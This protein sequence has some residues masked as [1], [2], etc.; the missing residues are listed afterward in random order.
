MFRLNVGRAE[1]LVVGEGCRPAELPVVRTLGSDPARLGRSSESS[2]IHGRFLEH[3]N[4][5]SIGPVS[6]FVGRCGPICEGPHRAFIEAVAVVTRDSGGVL[7]R[8]AVESGRDTRQVPLAST[9]GA[10]ARR[11][12]GTGCGSV[13]DSPDSGA[14]QWLSL[15]DRRR[16]VS[17]WS[18]STPHERHGSPEADR[19]AGASACPWQL[20][21]ASRRVRRLRRPSIGQ[22]WPRGTSTCCGLHVRPLSEIGGAYASVDP[23][24]DLRPVCPNCA[25]PVILHLGAAVVAEHRRACGN[26]GRQQRHAEL[27][28]CSRRAGY[29]SIFLTTAHSAPAAAELGRST[30]EG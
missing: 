11:H 30:A 24:E 7:D 22:R 18:R 6:K 25:R 9:H 26:S 1:V 12:G 5:L 13:R 29:D 2:E 10:T 19:P 23:V 14:G 27:R 8:I 17:V 16:S 28:R 3:P 20:A 15:V 4:V 21:V